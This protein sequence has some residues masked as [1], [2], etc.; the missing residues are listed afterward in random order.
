MSVDLGSSHP[1]S[2]KRNHDDAEDNIDGSS[3]MD[4]DGTPAR[5][6]GTTLPTDVSPQKNTT[7]PPGAALASNQRPKKPGRPKGSAMHP[8]GVAGDPTIWKRIAEIEE[9]KIP[10]ELEP[11]LKAKDFS[12]TVKLEPNIGIFE[13]VKVLLPLQLVAISEIKRSERVK[14]LDP[15]EI[16]RFFMDRYKA[17][18]SAQARVTGLEKITAA[19][20]DNWTHILEAAENM[21]WICHTHGHGFGCIFF[22]DGVFTFKSSGVRFERAL[23]FFGR[24]RSHDDLGTLNAAG[25]KLVKEIVD[26][27]GLSE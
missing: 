16:Q 8:P 14:N 15:H 18:S 7:Q 26:M 25:D 3:G 13:G 19:G 24:L 11:V 20:R 2:L 5:Q 23:P 17:M 12:Q 6:S 9:P 1:T 27:Y 22:L 10:A 4:T 21:R